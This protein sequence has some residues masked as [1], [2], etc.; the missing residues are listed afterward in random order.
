MYHQLFWPQNYG[1]SPEANGLT[2]ES[3]GIAHTLEASAVRLMFD[4]VTGTPYVRQVNTNKLPD[5][6]LTQ[7]FEAA[8]PWMLK[9]RENCLK[10]AGGDKT[11]RK[12]ALEAFWVARE[13]LDLVKFDDFKAAL[14]LLPTLE[15]LPLA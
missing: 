14:G 3:L 12:P 2:N 7:C 13:I 10:V 8:L 6:R 4:V 5:N 11:A 1:A 9:Y 15:S